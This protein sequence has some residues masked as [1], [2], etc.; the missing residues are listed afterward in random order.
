[1]RIVSLYLDPAVNTTLQDTH[2]SCLSLP[3]NDPS[4]LCPHLQHFQI[5]DYTSLFHDPRETTDVNSWSGTAL[6]A[7]IEAGVQNKTLLSFGLLSFKKQNIT[8]AQLARF[9]ELKEQGLNLRLSEVEEHIPEHND[10]P[11]AGLVPLLLQ[12]GLQNPEILWD[13][14]EHPE[15]RDLL[16]NAVV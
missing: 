4:S 5:I 1:F 3:A 11:T 16:S 2:L 12:L 14:I 15:L 9:R 6:A 13:I 8:T 7:F 10:S